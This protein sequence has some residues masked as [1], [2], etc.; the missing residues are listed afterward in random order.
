MPGRLPTYAVIL[1]GGRGTRFW[2]LSRE[3]HPKQLL[4]L[5][6]SR[7][8]L[9]E[10]WRRLVVLFPP[11]RIYVVTSRAQAAAV[12]RQLPALAPAN[13][14]V[15]PVGR[16]TAAAIALAAAH[17]RREER[18][19]ALL[20]V[21]P[22]DHAIARPA[23]FRRAVRAALAAAAAEACAV[24]CGIPPTEPHTG[25]GYIERGRI[26]RRLNGLRVYR[27]RRFTEKPDR[28]TA[29]RYLRSG[30]YFWNAGMFFWR[31]ATFDGLLRRYL[32][33]TAH[34]LERL[35]PA[36]GTPGF[37]R[38]L[39]AVYPKLKNIS[40]DY[41]LAEPAAA[42]GRVRVVPAAMGWSDLGS[43][44]ALYDFLA[45]RPRDN[46]LRGAVLA[47]AARGNLIWTQKKF[48]SAVGV[49][50]LVVVETPD[51]LLVTTRDHAQE[52]SQVVQYL[53]KK[54]R[55]DLL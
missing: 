26:W 41:A 4:P 32:P 21:F 9:Q 12:R 16:N 43:W 37:H 38:K 24:V 7:S 49:D 6:G 42:D 27:A 33:A 18:N 35:R 5:L 34:A 51:A 3:R 54:K 23:L 31:L 39:A 8:L 45:A 13:L 28:A 55:W 10:S 19:D 22:A 36:I 14:L 40:V 29:A 47:R 48:A 1:A 30:R 20:A 44:A 52:V 17:I 11:R 2:P 25:Y 53:E 15:E 50:N 46:V